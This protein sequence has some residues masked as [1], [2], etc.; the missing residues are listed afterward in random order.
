MLS[1]VSEPPRATASG[2]TVDGSDVVLR[3][4][5]TIH[6]RPTGSGDAEGVAAFL[7]GL[8]P[9]ASWF[10]FLGSGPQE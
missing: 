2:A 3:D 7:R 5:S 4:G 6:L 8:S 9:E 1:T 10:R